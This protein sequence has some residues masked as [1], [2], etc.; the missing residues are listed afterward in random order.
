MKNILAKPERK[1]IFPADAPVSRF[2]EKTAIRYSLKGTDY[3]LEIARYDEYRR[4]EVS[5]HPGQSGATIT[6]GI[7]ETPFT[8]WGASIFGTN[9]D[10]LLGGHANL[11]VGQA[12]RYSPSLSTFFPPKVPLPD[13][14]GA[15]GFWEFID[16][17]KLAAELLGPTQPSILKSTGPNTASQAVPSSAAKVGLVKEAAGSSAGSSPTSMTSPAGM[18][19]ADLG[20]LF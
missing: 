5:V 6:G 16:L 15:K 9:W 11:P 19:Y 4:A 7:S 13:E 8:T 18:L 10:N 3:I 12:A 20:T 17:V 14:D 1:V 2:V